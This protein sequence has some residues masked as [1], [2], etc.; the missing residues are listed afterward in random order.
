MPQVNQSVQRDASNILGVQ[1][2][3]QQVQPAVQEAP[4]ATVD[5]GS[6]IQQ[7]ADSLREQGD[8]AGANKMQEIANMAN[9][10]TGYRKQITDTFNR[11]GALIDSG[12]EQLQ[13]VINTVDD[14]YKNQLLREQQNFEMQY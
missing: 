3:Q 12:N 1:Q 14:Q 2:P 11:V 13:R 5:S 8:V 6:Q 10:E 4:S 9:N 7:R